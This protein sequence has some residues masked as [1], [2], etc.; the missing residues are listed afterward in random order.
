MASP[1]L[2]DKIDG[3]NAA[4][5]QHCA[6]LAAIELDIFTSLKDGSLTVEQIADAIAVDSS[7]LALMLDPLVAVGLLSVNDNIFSN[8]SEA[9][10]FLVR[11]SP[12][13]MGSEPRM[14][15]PSFGWGTMLKTA[16]SIRAGAPQEKLDFSGMSAEDLDERFYS[17]FCPIAVAEGRDLATK[18]D[19]SSHRHLLDVGGGT[20]GL[21]IA[22]TEAYPN[23]R[24]TVADLPNVT[25]I[26]ERYLREAGASDRID[27]VSADVT[28]DSLGGTYDLVVLKSL[29][30]VLSRDQAQRALH[31]VAAHMEPGA[32]LFILGIVLDSSRTSPER[33]LFFNMRAINIYAQGEAYTEQEYRDWL[34]DAGL[35]G[36]ERHPQDDGRSIVMARKPD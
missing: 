30:Q 23:M 1:H 15:R 34:A 10:D 25:P 6:L 12:A 9:N 19:F 13:Y 3:L 17:S 29:I 14:V 35:V 18:Y 33:A 24:A 36:F 4:A 5:T 7:R 11:G 26:T 32:S 27:I 20:G 21:A 8:S 16:D 2:P 31:N 28:Q 22:V